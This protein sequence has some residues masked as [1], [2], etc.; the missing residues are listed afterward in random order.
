MHAETLLVLKEELTIITSS[1]DDNLGINRKYSCLYNVHHEQR[2]NMKIQ[3][4]MALREP[5]ILQSS[6]GNGISDI[7]QEHLITRIVIIVLHYYITTAL[8]LW[9]WKTLMLLFQL[10]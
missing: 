10:I 3:Q 7:F 2:R 8:T 4:Q 1:L 6:V 9:P 5:T